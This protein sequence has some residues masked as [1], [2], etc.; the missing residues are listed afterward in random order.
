MCVAE[1]CRNKKRFY[2]W[3]GLD[4]VLDTQKNPKTPPDGGLRTVNHFY[5][6]LFKILLSQMKDS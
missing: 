3:K 5:I 4:N 1:L 2:F 6:N